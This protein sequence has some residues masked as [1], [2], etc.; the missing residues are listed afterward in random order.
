MLP[1]SSTVTEAQCANATVEDIGLVGAIRVADRKTNLQSLSQVI[2]HVPPSR[3]ANKWIKSCSAPV[4]GL[5][6]Q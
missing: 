6:E 1:G 4:G 5:R 3:M 2:W